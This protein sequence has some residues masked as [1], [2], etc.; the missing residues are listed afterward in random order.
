VPQTKTKYD[1]QKARSRNR[2]IEARAAQKA[3]E[4][5]QLNKQKELINKQAFIIQALA[6]FESKKT[7][8]A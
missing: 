3:H 6:R 8:R 7:T 4:K 2:A 5:Q 1:P